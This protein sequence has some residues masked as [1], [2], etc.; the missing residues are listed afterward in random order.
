MSQPPK[1][2]LPYA[3]PGLRLV[4]GPDDASEAQN[5]RPEKPAMI[6]G[7][8]LEPA[9]WQALCAAQPGLR[10]VLN[11][12]YSLSSSIGKEGSLSDGNTAFLWDTEPHP[13][14]RIETNE[15]QLLDARLSE[16]SLDPVVGG[17]CLS[18]APE[19]TM[20]YR[21]TACSATLAEI[22][23][24]ESRRFITAADGEEH[25]LLDTEAA[26]EPVLY[27][28]NPFNGGSESDIFCQRFGFQA[29]SEEQTYSGG[30]RIAQFLTP[31]YEGE[32]VRSVTVLEKYISYF[33][34]RPVTVCEKDAIWIPASAPVMWGW[35][36][37]TEPDG[38]EGWVI[39]RR[40]LVTPQVGH[41]GYEVPQWR[42]NAVDFINQSP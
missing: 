7:V 4:T 12:G 17:H 20:R 40:K 18:M 36:I 19:F 3:S 15:F 35:S 31:W 26:A 39:T 6:A 24:V 30:G 16:L 25:V 22:R 13:D 28:Q 32:E 11:G 34:Q 23:L 33:M 14:V 9:Q 29:K 27:S 37:R 8:A 2:R 1:M 21:T 41:D 38:E 42:H 10:D 5:Q